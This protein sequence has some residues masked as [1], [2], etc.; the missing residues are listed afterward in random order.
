MRRVL[1]LAQRAEGR[2]SPNP[3]VGAVIVK[4]G[5]VV[6]EGYHRRAGGPHAEIAALR[7]AGARARG[8]V[9]FVNLEPCCHYGKTPPCTDALISAGI[10]RVVVGM[11]DP[12]P[13]VRGGGLRLLRRAGIAVETGILRSECERVNEAFIKYIV[14]RRPFVILKS[15]LSLDGKTA[16][17]SGESRW[18][19]GPRSR[20]W[21]HRL[22]DTVDAIL[23]GTETVL[24]DD[25]SLTARLAGKR[26]RNPV[27]VVLDRRHRLP[28]R[29]QVFAGAPGD[30]ILYFTATAPKPDRAK[31]LRRRGVEIVIV[32]E[33]RDGLSLAE[34]LLRLGE[35]GI[36]RV[37]IEGGAKL[38]A[39]VLREKLADKIV[40]FLA[41]VLIGGESAPGV[42]GGEGV[43]LLSQAHR[44]RRMECRRV[45]EDILVEGYFV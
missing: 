11:K 20:R 14:S 18:I 27:R 21:V 45:G 28:L 24:K 40:W 19:S 10:R 33:K 9:M 38:N 6:G 44:I 30:R 13:L 29:A 25:P 43:R 4:S 3:M 5:R 36:T 23:V 35:R 1:E 39:T 16:T 7:R 37:L 15:A 17:A 41:P 2:T 12:N 8:G 26:G 32:A 22:R 34:V 42:I 31:A